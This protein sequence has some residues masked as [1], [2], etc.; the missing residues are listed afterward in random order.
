MIQKL[1][2]KLVIVTKTLC[3]EK[4]KVC[5]SQSKRQKLE[6]SKEERQKV[7]CALEWLVKFNPC[8]RE[9]NIDWSRLE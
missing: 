6:Q 2:L 7:L 9:I 1:I 8:Y 4:K 5:V 3:Q